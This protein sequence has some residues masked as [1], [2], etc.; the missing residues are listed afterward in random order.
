[1]R[2]EPHVKRSQ[3]AQREEAVERRARDA[4]AVGPPDELIVQLLVSRDDGANRFAGP[5]KG[6]ISGD[7]MRVMLLCA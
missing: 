5:T 2:I 6:S 7:E 3:A 1:M 4:E